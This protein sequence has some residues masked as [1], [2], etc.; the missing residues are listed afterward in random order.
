LAD[1]HTITLRFGTGR[2]EAAI[3]VANLHFE[4]PRIKGDSSVCS[5]AALRRALVSPIGCPP[6]E[7]L[8]KG[9]RRVVML[10]DDATRP[11][12]AHMLV[13]DILE[14]LRHAGVSRG[15]VT[16]LVAT[17]T[18]RAMRPDEIDAK[19]GHEVRQTYEV[20][21]HD[22]RDLDMLVELGHT[23][24]G[25]PI[26][27]NRI[28]AEAQL[29]IG[30]GNIVP[31]RY[32]GWAG[33]A[34]IVQPGVC[35]EDTTAATHLMMTEDPD[36]RLGVM[37]NRVR[38]EMEAVAD[39]VNLQFVVNTILDRGGQ[40]KGVV[41]GDVRKAFRAGVET[42]RGTYTIQI[43]GRADVVIASAFPSD[44]NFWQAGKALYAAD[45]AVRRG[46]I[47]ILVSP[48]YEGIGEHSEFAGL[49]AE[50]AGAIRSMIRANKVEDR[51]GA[52]AA[53][54][55]AEVRSRAEICIVTQHLSAGDAEALRMRRYTSLQNAVDDALRKMGKTGKVMVLH[56]AVEMV[57]VIRTEANQS[58]QVNHAS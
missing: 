17:G 29:V 20:V 15:A 45:L 30:V 36:V 21:S 9:K 51:I 11:T 44:M 40:I 4:V 31:H 14:R 18:H 56:E 2:L 26:S 57:P 8:A 33:G 50:E 34:K 16:I 13:P 53:L 28:V 6:L 1:T 49:C 19:V 41:A 24:N 22:Y 7:V 27:V 39:R 42:A 35:G 46:G 58:A 52:A 3:P 43:P 12:P 23:A 54:A 32:C 55:V 48:C 25:T 5:S 10:V 38:H 37:E 47:I